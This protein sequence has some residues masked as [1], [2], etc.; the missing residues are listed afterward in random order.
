MVDRTQVI[1]VLERL[2]P[3]RTS[4]ITVAPDGKVGFVLAVDGLDRAAAAK[5]QAEVETAVRGITGV[6]GVRAELSDETE[7]PL[8]EPGEPETGSEGS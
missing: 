1:E 6:G 7:H 4:G 5:L 8:T 3:G 2:A